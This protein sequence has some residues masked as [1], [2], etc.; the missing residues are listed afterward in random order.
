M[1]RIVFKIFIFFLFIYAI[2]GFFLIPYLIN[3]KLPA[4]FSKDINA[5]LIIESSHFNPFALTLNLKDV[6]L[7]SDKGQELVSFDALDVDVDALE[8]LVGDIHIKEITLTQPQINLVFSKEKKLNILEIIPPNND[9][10]TTVSKGKLPKILFDR[11][12]IVDGAINYEDDSKVK[13]YKAGVS[14]LNFKLFDLDTS[15]DNSTDTR[16]ASSI[17]RANL[18]DG[19]SLRIVNKLESLTPVVVDG[20]IDLQRLQLKTIW[21]YIQEPFHI[22]LAKGY[23]DAKLTYHVDLDKLKSTQ[24]SKGSL[25]LADMLITPKKKSTDLLSIKEIFLDD[26]TA[27]P[28]QTKITIGSIDVD[29]LKANIKRVGAS[30]VDWQEYLKV[31][32]AKTEPSSKK[33]DS[34]PLSLSLHNFTLRNSTIHLQDM[35]LT[36]KSVIALN[37]ISLHVSNINTKKDTKIG[38]KLALQTDKA[39]KISADGTV[40][41][42]PL[43]QEGGIK[44]TKLPLTYINPYLDL[45][46]YVKLQNTTVSYEAK[47]SYSTQ[48]NE[49]ALSSK[50]SLGIDN[51]FLS[52]TLNGDKLLAI[53]ALRVDPYTF[54]LN[55]LRLYID[56]VLVDGLYINAIITKDK[57]MNFAK[58]LKPDN[59]KKE[60]QTKSAST[61]KSDPFAF[62]IMQVNLKN[63][64]ADFSDL[65]IPL[66][67]KTHI[68]DLNGKI[69]PIS[70][71]ADEVSF[72]DLD[73]VVNQYGSAKIKGSINTNNPKEY[74]DMNL[75][76]R[77]LDMNAISP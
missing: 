71:R 3:N 55:P 43:T 16:Q 14:G 27:L 31:D 12:A 76:F 49:M 39:G 10:N 50:G 13:V 68:H 33:G 47:E 36:K 65:S 2:S 28:L 15:D 69:T 67:F 22:N 8:L 37:N 66:E 57:S 41:L 4:L 42:D 40:R 19:A 61:P 24:I 64:S 20:D 29:K 59:S 26:L 38:Y 75:I 1:K 7:K 5:T 60:P 70:T 73:G 62:K 44:I 30:E 34:Q 17:V 32:A 56:K 74:T 48:N 46:A 72:V 58:L 45:F 52:S 18:S 21:S 35:T 54:E 77:N 63:S 23:A 11:I 51:L 53:K 25:K 9:Q 6:V